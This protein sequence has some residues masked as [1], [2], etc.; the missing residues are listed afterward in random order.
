[1]KTEEELIW[2][3]YK[4]ITK[5]L[6]TFSQIINW[7][8]HYNP[9]EDEGLYASD[10]KSIYLIGSRAKRTNRNDSD[11]D[12]AVEF[13]PNDIENTGLSPIQLTE[14]LHQNFGNLMPKFNNLPIDIQ[15]FETDGSEQQSYSKIQLR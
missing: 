5:K 8:D 7:F 3:N 2:E 13:S 10:I 1:M 14:L 9:F 6:P 4:S 12:L 11:Y 15:I